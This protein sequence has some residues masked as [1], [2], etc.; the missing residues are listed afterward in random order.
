MCK[1]SICNSN[2]KG[3]SFLRIEEK[4]VVLDVCPNCSDYFPV[5]DDFITYRVKLYSY[6]Y[7]K[8]GLIPENDL[9]SVSFNDKKKWFQMYFEQLGNICIQLSVNKDTLEIDE[10]IF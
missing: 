10:H 8:L 6:I 4:N 2:I 9:Y 1:C 3:D 5:I 7:N